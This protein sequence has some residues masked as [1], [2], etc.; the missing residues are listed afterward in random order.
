[1]YNCSKLR[2]KTE[3]VEWKLDVCRKNVTT[4]LNA[5]RI[6]SLPDELILEIL[7]CMDAKLAVQTS[8]L[9]TRWKLLWTSIPCLNFFSRSFDSSL[10]V[11]NFVSNFLSRRNHQVDVSSVKLDFEVGSQEI[12]AQIV[13]YAVS[14]NVQKLLVIVNNKRL[15]FQDAS[16]CPFSSK[17]L[18]KVTFSI[19]CRTPTT[20]WDFPALTTMHLE[21]VEFFDNPVDLFSKCVNLKNLTL[22]KFAVFVQVFVI[23]IPQLSNL[24]LNNGKNSIIV[25]VV[26]PQLENLTIRNCSIEKL[27]A[28]QGL[29]SLCYEDYHPPQL[30]RDC[31][32]SL[33]KASV[34]FHFSRITK[35]YKEIDARETINMLQELHSA[36]CLTLNLDIVELLNVYG[37]LLA[38]VTTYLDAAIKMDDASAKVPLDTYSSTIFES[39]I[40]AMQ[41]F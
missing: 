1:M 18:K 10:K 13:N 36:K 6:S 31:F 7:S 27:N 38:D 16:L 19:P 33:N 26:A 9:S 39:W 21:S 25:N 32:N 20:T 4:L 23:S 24:R 30:P 41:V 2:T 8:L 34:N 37:G 22:E 40:H 28:P 3:G 17:S 15:L 5:D 35:P 11:G 14:R 29:T 12:L